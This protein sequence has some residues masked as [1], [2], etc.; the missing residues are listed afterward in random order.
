MSQ[1]LGQFGD[2][3]G[4][5]GIAIVLTELVLEQERNHVDEI[6]LGDLDHLQ[7]GE[8]QLGQRQRGRV[9]QSRSCRGMAWQK[10][11]FS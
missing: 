9:D 2:T 7:L 4:V 10:S 1:F 6:L 3:G 8:E 5:Q 11:S